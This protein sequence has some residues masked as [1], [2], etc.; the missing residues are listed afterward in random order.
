[1]LP[2]TSAARA[3]NGNLGDDECRGGK[4]LQRRPQT[5]ETCGLVNMVLPA[6]L[7][8]AGISISELG[9]VLPSSSM[10]VWC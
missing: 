7:R 5:F 6:L 8:S 4:N 3:S 10:P 1:M 2:D 9:A